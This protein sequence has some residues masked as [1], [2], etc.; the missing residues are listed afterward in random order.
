SLVGEKRSGVVIPRRAQIRSSSAVVAADLMEVSRGNRLDILGAEKN[1]SDLWFHV[2]T[3]NADGAEGWIEAQNILSNEM[4]E[5]SQKLWLEDKATPAQ[6]TGQLRSRTNLRLTPDRSGT[7]NIMFKLDSG[8]QFDIV[9]WKIVPKPRTGEVTDNDDAPRGGAGQ[10]RGQRGK[11]AGSR[12]RDDNVPEDDNE[13]WYKVRLEQTSSAAPAGWVYGKQVELTVPGDIIFYR[14]GREFVA[15]QQLDS[16]AAVQNGKS[17]DGASEANPASWVILEKGSSKNQRQTDGPDFDRIYVL[18][19]DPRA[20]EHYTAYRS[21]NLKGRLPLRVFEEAGQ[22]MFSVNVSV[23]DSVNIRE[24]N[25]V[26]K[27][28]RYKV[29]KD[30]KGHL[31][32]EAVK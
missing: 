27:E 11:D 22:K 10:Q 25:V 7:D 26:V 31:R 20:Q 12:T 24:A 15:W 1:D 21:P 16:D 29:K 4:F 3:T 14:T 19:Y 32:V 17:R 30:E 9:G 8:S 23:D 28:M 13:L 2:R 5:R 6:A 18:G